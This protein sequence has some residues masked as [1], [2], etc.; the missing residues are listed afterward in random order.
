M[1]FF[2][3]RFPDSIAQGATGGPRFSTSK[4]VVTGGARSANKNWTAPLHEYNVAQGI[5]T[6]AQFDQVRQF[7]WV[8]DGDYDGFRFKDYADFR[9]GVD[10]GVLTLV[11]GANYQLGF[12]YAYG[13]RSVVRRIQ[14]PVPGTVSVF[15]LRVG[16]TTDVTGTST[17]D[18]TTGVVA[19]T[20]HT[21]GDTYTWSGEFDVPVAFKEGVLD[22]KQI[23]QENS[24][25][26]DWGAITL[27]EIR[28]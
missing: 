15:R 5:K 28:V 19:I 17:I 9:V 12:T 1:A 8:V 11:S 27:E 6:V 22:A 24:L 13:A 26:M 2:E 10:R 21:L 16:V 7:F 25:Y 4:A 18:T 14:K 23:G 20:G 3:E